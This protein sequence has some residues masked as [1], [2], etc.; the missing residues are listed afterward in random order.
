MALVRHGVFLCV[1]E[2][3]AP[4]GDIISVSGSKALGSAVSNTNVAQMD[5]DVNRCFAG[6]FVSPLSVAVPQTSPL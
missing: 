5:V 3:A 2:T 4:S 1:K 6:G